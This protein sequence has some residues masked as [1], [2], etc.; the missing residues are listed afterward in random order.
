MEFREQ[1]QQQHMN[2]VPQATEE[3][4]TMEQP[5]RSRRDHKSSPSVFSAWAR[6]QATGAAYC[7]GVLCLLFPEWLS[8]VYSMPFGVSH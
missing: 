7:G 4:L 3:A 8:G 1:Q 5:R 2:E 6:A